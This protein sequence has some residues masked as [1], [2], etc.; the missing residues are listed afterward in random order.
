MPAVHHHRLQQHAGDLAGVLDEHPL[1]DLEVVVGH[2]Q[3]QGDD[4][5]RDAAGGDRAG[6]PVDRVD[7]LQGL[8]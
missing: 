8:K 5:G 7:L 6:R 1:G 3:G 4:L 2:D